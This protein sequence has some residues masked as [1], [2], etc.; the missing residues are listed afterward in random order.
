MPAPAHAPASFR[1]VVLDDNAVSRRLVERVLERHFGCQVDSFGTAAA[2]LGQPD[3]DPPDLY[4]L[5]IVLEGENGIEVCR[6]L[7]TRPATRDIPVIL[8]SEYGQPHTRIEA[9]RAGGV[10]YLDKPFYPEEFLQ[11]VRGAVERHRHQRM[12][13]AQTREQQ[14]LLRVLCHDLRN[15]VG[16]AHSIL[17]LAA[18]TQ[19]P[20]EL[21]TDLRLATQA[22]QSALDL[23]AHVGEY[24]TLLD[25]SRPFKIE[26]VDLAA[27]CAESFAVLG[28]AA[29]A[30]KVRL[31]QDI[32]PGVHLATNRVVLVHNI[33]NN[34]LNNA[35]KFSRPGGRVWLEATLDPT[36]PGTGEC[37]VTVRDEGI[38]IPHFILEQLLK[39]QPV[40]SRRGTAE[41]KG[42]GVGVTLVDFHVRR[43]GGRVAIESHT[44]AP[45]RPDQP[46]GTRVTLHFPLS[47][48]APDSPGESHQTAAAA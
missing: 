42:T 25:E 12:L 32:P 41:E 36:A 38:G 7:K 22:T 14:A 8:F 37:I 17:R 11:R 1:I 21:D 30:K 20:Q 45:S 35:I 46:S 48:L 29:T 26:P 16:A 5:D 34:L 28:P 6:R 44:S 19:D 33:L 43:C 24:R 23:I 3:A 40:A 10:D 18:Y 27:A 13:E 4:L 39:S 9:L 47:P 31:L 2:L 15:S